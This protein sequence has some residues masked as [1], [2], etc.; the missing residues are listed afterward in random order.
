MDGWAI[1]YGLWTGK[2]LCWNLNNVPLSYS[3]FS[4]REKY[5]HFSENYRAVTFI[6]LKSA[7]DTI[8]LE[9]LW[10]KLALIRKFYL[11]SHTYI[12]CEEKRKLAMNIPLQHWVKQGCDL[13]PQLSNL[14]LN[15]LKDHLLDQ[16]FHSPS[17]NNQS[18]LVLFY[19]NNTVLLSRPIVGFRK[20]LKVFSN[21]CQEEKL[22]I[23][24]TKTKVLMFQS[25]Q[26]EIDGRPIKQVFQYCYLRIS[27]HF[28]ISWYPH[29]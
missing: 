16:S 17:L 7:F 20:T 2:F 19:V 27:F 3:S 12:W 8:S 14:Y 29:I 5:S 6:G 10:R 15:Y 26:W 4:G 1:N 24:Y 23:K 22:S 11:E 13:A 18:I 28:H 9:H 25:T 21:Y